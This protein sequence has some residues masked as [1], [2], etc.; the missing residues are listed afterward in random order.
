LLGPSPSFLDLDIEPEGPV[1]GRV[2]VNRFW[3]SEEQVVCPTLR[4]CL[5]TIP[6]GVLEPEQRLSLNLS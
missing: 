4:R 3:P 5:L 1:V 2:G 6:K